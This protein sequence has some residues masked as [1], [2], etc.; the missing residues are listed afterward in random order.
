MC[1]TWLVWP[2]VEPSFASA[3]ELP[4]SV[5]STAVSCCCVLRGSPPEVISRLLLFTPLPPAPFSI[6]SKWQFHF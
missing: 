3:P 4:G 2:Q 1:P 5:S 6:N